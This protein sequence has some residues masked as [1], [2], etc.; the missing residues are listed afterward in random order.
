M[1]CHTHPSGSA[2]RWCARLKH[3]G[4]LISNLWVS[5]DWRR[6]KRVCVR[7]CGHALLKH[8]H[9]IV[10]TLGTTRLTTARESNLTNEGDI[11][12]PNKSILTKFLCMSSIL[13]LMLVI[14]LS[15]ML[16]G[17]LIMSCVKTHKEKPRQGSYATCSP[18]INSLQSTASYAQTFTSYNE[19]K[20]ACVCA[21]WDIHILSLPNTSLL[22]S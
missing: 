2:A 7:I 10:H 9:T 18:V 4:R 17:F 16:K 1:W 21:N 11:K 5:H 20:V 3:F 14:T 15:N 13:F 22:M 8:T 6:V 19:L 12:Y